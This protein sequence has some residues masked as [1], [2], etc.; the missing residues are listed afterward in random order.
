MNEIGLK[1]LDAEARKA[2]S[3][4]MLQK[5]AFTE[6]CIITA[7]SN[8]VEARQALYSIKSTILCSLQCVY[9]AQQKQLECL[10]CMECKICK[11]IIRYNAPY[12]YWPLQNHWDPID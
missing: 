1:I 3:Q 8:M 12:L 4:R 9:E 7:Q 10:R 5:L 2:V 6:Q 11:N